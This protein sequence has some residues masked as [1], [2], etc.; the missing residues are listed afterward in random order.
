MAYD[1]FDDHLDRLS[2][3][4]EAGMPVAEYLENC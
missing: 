4:L 3:E 2:I 1:L